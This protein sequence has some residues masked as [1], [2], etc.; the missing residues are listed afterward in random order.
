MGQLLLGH[1]RGRLRG[2]SGD[3]ARR[4]APARYA[5]A[6][7]SRDYADDRRGRADDNNESTDSHPGHLFFTPPAE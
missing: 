3:V 6:D 7:H 5:D 4:C 2:Y 1:L